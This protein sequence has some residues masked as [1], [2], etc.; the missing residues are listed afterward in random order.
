MP[1][2][3]KVAV[4]EDITT[5]QLPVITILCLLGVIFIGREMWQRW[6]IQN[7]VHVPLILTIILLGVAAGTFPFVRITVPVPGAMASTLSNEDGKLLLTALL[8][9]VY[10]AFD[11][12]EETDVYDKLAL[13]VSGDLLEEIYLQ[14]RKSFEIKRAGG[15]QAKVKEVE[16]LKVQTE[17]L[18]EHGLAFAFQTQW[19]AVG[20]VG[21]WGHV[22]TRKN[23]YDARIIVNAIDGNWK[24]SGMELLEEKRIDPNTRPE[25]NLRKDTDDKGS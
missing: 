10:R 7:P 24:I 8:K 16:V 5:K 13:S 14:N 23:Y 6:R 1:Q 20:T 15:A 17:R 25:T 3:K 11:F 22:H 19:T 18:I 4:A 2:V 9:N 21:H 12:R